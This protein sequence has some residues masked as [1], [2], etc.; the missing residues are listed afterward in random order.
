MLARASLLYLTEQ[1][2]EERLTRRN[3]NTLKFSSKEQVGVLLKLR[4]RLARLSG[5]WRYWRR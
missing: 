1:T 4:R 2:D 3:V 5:S